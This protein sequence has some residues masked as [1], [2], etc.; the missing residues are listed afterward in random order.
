MVIHMVI[1]AVIGMIGIGMQ[2]AQSSLS[3]NSLTTVSTSS[4]W[5]VQ[6]ISIVSRDATGHPQQVNPKRFRISAAPENS[7]TISLMIESPVILTGIHLLSIRH[8]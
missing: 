3:F 4:P 1:G 6:A 2:M 5:M 7:L 8:P